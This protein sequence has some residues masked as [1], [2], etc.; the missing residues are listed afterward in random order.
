M[1]DPD[2][3]DVATT[4]C[5]DEQRSASAYSENTCIHFPSRWEPMEE[6]RSHYADLSHPPAPPL[7]GELGPI[8]YA[9]IREQTDN[10][11]LSTAIEATPVDVS[12]V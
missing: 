8:Q 7:P 11:T 2:Q 6:K 9:T 1:K 4:R 3:M 5:L 12:L 10:T